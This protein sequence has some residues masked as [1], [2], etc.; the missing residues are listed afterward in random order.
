M[1]NTSSP[2]P[3]LAPPG[4]GLPW[5]ELRIARLLFGLSRWSYGR[6]AATRKFLDEQNQIAALL[7]RCDPTLACERVLI[8]R[9]R[10]LEDSSRHWS[11]A[12]TL[13]HL[14]ITNTS[15][16]QI[17]RC[18]AGNSI[19]PGVAST[20]AVKPSA[21]ASLKV[22]HAY[23]QACSQVLEAVRENPN[24]KTAVKFAHP[25]FGPMNAEGWHL[26]AGMHMGIHRKQIE[27]ILKGLV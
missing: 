4:A 21:D 17:I 18:L 16:V 22:V 9:L 7:N 14:R 27:A 3:A 19:P 20:A 24:L 12:M 26:L 25:W 1:P 11:V 23:N 8:P 6:D 10:G 15:F 5:P 13:D 2:S